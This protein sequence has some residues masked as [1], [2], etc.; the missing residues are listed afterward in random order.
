MWNWLKRW[1]DRVKTEL[2][3]AENDSEKQKYIHQ[4]DQESGPLSDEEK[5]TAG[6]KI[7]WWNLVLDSRELT[8]HCISGW[9]KTKPTPP[10]EEKPE[11]SRF[12]ERGVYG[13]Y[14]AS[15]QSDRDSNRKESGGET[16]LPRPAVCAPPSAS[17]NTGSD[18]EKLDSLSLEDTI[19]LGKVEDTSSFETAREPVRDEERGSRQVEPEDSPPPTAC[20][21]MDLPHTGGNTEKLDPSFPEITVILGEPENTTSFKVTRSPDQDEEYRDRK[22]QTG[23]SPPLAACAPPTPLEK[24][25]PKKRRRGIRFS[26]GA[27]PEEDASSLLFYHKQH[28]EQR[29]KAFTEKEYLQILEEQSE[30]AGVHA[31]V[32]IDRPLLPP[33]FVSAVDMLMTQMNLSRNEFSDRSLLDVKIYDRIRRKENW[34][35]KEDT[36]KAILFA[37]RPNVITA[38]QLYHLAGY[39]FRECDEDLLLL[40]MFGV[41]D[42]DIETYNNVM[43]SRGLR[44]LGS[45]SKK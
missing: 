3:L 7:A 9:M 34:H 18:T 6:T 38:L 22:S 12:F 45:K 42:Y 15:I 35:P 1:V 19:V 26:Y 4:R 30:R 40:C 17:E 28:E 21:T 37:L 13:Q 25:G 44:Q 23:H 43:A 20:P 39:T 10:A 33:H 27:S 5:Y 29:E 16:S 2:G 24:S 8:F 11:W 31:P 14:D 32:H 41:G 36:C